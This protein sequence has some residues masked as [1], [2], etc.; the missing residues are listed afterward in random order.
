MDYTVGIAAISGRVSLC[1]VQSL[2]RRSPDVTIKGYCRQ[3]SNLPQQAKDHPR[4]HVTQGQY[5]DVDGL[6]SFVKGCDIVICGYL[7]DNNS[8]VDLQK[9]LIDVCVEEKVP[10]YMASD[11]TI[12]LTALEHNEYRKKEPMLQIIDYLEKVD[13]KPVHILNGIFVDTLFSDFHYFWD[14]REKKVRYYGTG[15]EVWEMSTYESTAEYTAAVA[16]DPDAHGFL[17]CTQLDLPPKF[18]QLLTV[19]SPGRSTHDP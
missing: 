15:D 3:P 19:R 9:L 6:R 18:F 8:M 7:A 1:I 2:L 14:P 10:R 5:D 12:E 4:I 13:I 17:R 16:L 11:W